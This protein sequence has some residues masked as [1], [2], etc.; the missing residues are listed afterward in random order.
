MFG[1][2]HKNIILKVFIALLL[3][4]I[5]FVLAPYGIH[6][7]YDD[8]MITFDWITFFPL[9]V[10]LAYGWKIALY[11]AMVTFIWLIPFRLW[12]NNGWA[13]VPTA[14]LWLVWL[15]WHG[16]YSEQRLKKVWWWNNPLVVQV[17]FAVLYFIHIYPGYHFLYALNPTPWEPNAS[18]NIPIYVSLSIAVKSTFTMYMQ[19]LA[20]FLAIQIP[21]VRKLLR[22]PEDSF[23]NNNGRILTVVTIGAFATYLISRILISVFIFRTLSLNILDIGSPYDTMNILT[24]IIVALVVAHILI[25][26]SIQSTKSR[27]AE[28]RMALQMKRLSDNIVS[29][30]VYQIAIKADLKA[31]EFIYISAS[32]E[33]FLGISPARIYEDPN[34]LYQKVYPADIEILASAETEAMQSMAVFHAE[35]RFIQDHEKVVWFQLASSPHK[36]ENGDIIWDGV[37]IDISKRK[38]AEFE[39]KKNRDNLELIVEQRTR[40]LSDAVDAAQKASRSKSEFLAN[41]SHEIRT[42]LNGVIGMTSL[43]IDTPLNE[44]QKRFA[45]TVRSCGEAL[46]T[47]VNDILDFSKI[48]AGKLELD[49]YDFDLQQLLDDFTDTMAYRAQSKGLELIT[50]IGPNVPLN[51]NGDASRLRQILNNLVGNALKFTTHGEVSLTVSVVEQNSNSIQLKFCVRDT[52]LGIP[53]EKVNDIFDKFTQVDTSTT[54]K[55]GGTGLGLAICKQLA[56]LMGGSIGVRSP[57]YTQQNQKHGVG[58]EFWF[59]IQLKKQELAQNAEPSNEYSLLHKT[60]LIVDDNSTNCELLKQRL[61]S[62]GMHVYSC[63]DAPAALKILYKTAK[64]D[65]TIDVVIADMV[66]PEMNG[67]TLGSIIKS[68]PNFLKMKLILLSSISENEDKDKLDKIFDAV[69]T[70]P[71]RHLELKNILTMMF[72]FDHASVN[73]TPIVPVAEAETNPI[74]IRVA[75]AE[76]NLVNATVVMGLLKKMNLEAYACENGLELLELL[77]HTPCNM[78]IMDCLMPQ[79]DGYEATVAIRAGKSGD[80]LRNVVI[81]ALT[82]NALK[83]DREKCLAY[84][85]DDYLSKP[86][87][88]ETFM[89]KIKQWIPKLDE[90]ILEAPAEINKDTVVTH[91]VSPSENSAKLKETHVEYSTQSKQNLNSLANPLI[92]DLN[93]WNP[94]ELLERL[95][96]DLELMVQVIHIFKQETPKQRIQMGEL[97]KSKDY[98]A[99]SKIAHTLKGSAGNSACPK[100]QEQAHKIELQASNGDLLSIL[101]E[102]MDELDVLLQ[103]TLDAMQTY[104]DQSLG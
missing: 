40:E 39:L 94:H 34:A 26:S 64:D 55:Y 52:G 69:L 4:T 58:S 5:A 31:R 33:R 91:S 20:A 62:W 38:Q 10:T 88:T 54:R 79:M 63:L 78:I 56:T 53:P 16:Y 72:H 60:A 67:I 73:Y 80:A 83:G 99:L 84:G 48:E 18:T 15:V 75:V 46:L 86:I 81:I 102:W 92:H 103:C 90:S 96:G 74:K 95:Q 22:L 49:A 71:V 98:L 70:K 57:L 9:L 76:D 104:L 87:H 51:V 47:L 21:C 27:Q 100:L 2:T 24:V 1:D 29:G 50:G 45:E 68:D 82:A 85:M 6:I 23:A 101:N 30:F 35:I 37:A 66:M 97:L 59:T 77:K 14:L 19:V 36:Q 89:Q 28:L 3:N 17:P 7:Q 93:I 32:I 65:H 12:P 8:V 25:Y 43:L 13:N 61:E 44:D 41:M 42:P 11:T